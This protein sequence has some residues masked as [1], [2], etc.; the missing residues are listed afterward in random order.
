METDVLIIGAGVAGLAAA[1]KLSAAGLSVAILEARERVGGRILTLRDPL[2]PVPVELGAEFIHGRP[3]EIWEIVEAAPLAACDVL[4]PHDPSDRFD[5]LF[6]AME[7]AAGPDLT[8]AEFIATAPFDN[9]TKLRATAYVEGFNAARAER[10]GVR[11]LV[12]EAKASDSIGGD[13]TFRLLCGYDRICDHL[14]NGGLRA[15]L[16]LNTEVTALSWRPGSVEVEARTR[17]G[18]PAGPFTARRALVTVPLGVLQAGSIRFDPQPPNLEAARGL[19]MG[20]AVRMTLHFRERFWERHEGAAELG[21]LHVSDPCM[22]TWWSAQPVRAPLL[23]GWAGGAIAE[24]YAGRGDAFAVEQ[25][26]RALAR[27]LR[28]PQREIEAQLEAWYWHDWQ[29]DPYALGAYSYA[30]PGGGDA[31]RRLATPAAGTLFF[32]GEATNL[33]GHGAMVHGA[34]ASGRRAAAEILRA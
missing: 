31:R 22:P 21:F 15:A 3:P 9:E 20:Q 1:Q 33:E 10:I 13:Q 26:L 19:F 14:R 17:T 16:H 6:A 28:I 23:T 18:R 34:I 25:A 8:F 4:W 12:E 30:P 29:A 7:R 32:A 11:A 5:E 24:Q 27:V 2:V